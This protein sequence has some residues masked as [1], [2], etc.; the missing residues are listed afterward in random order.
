MCAAGVLALAVGFLYGRLMPAAN[1]AETTSAPVPT[2]DA[3]IAASGDADSTLPDPERPRPRDGKELASEVQ[4]AMDHLLAVFP[5][6]ADALEMNARTE[7]WLGHTAEADRLWKQCLE[8]DSNYVYAY[9]GMAKTAFERG[10]HQEAADLA[11]RAIEIDSS[12]FPARALRAEALIHLRRPQDAIAVLEDHIKLDPRSQGFYLLGQA[13]F[14]LKQWAQARDSLLAAI[15]QYP[16]YAEAYYLLSRTYRE[17]GD[18]EKAAQQLEQYR[19]L[20][21]PERMVQCNRPADVTDFDQMLVTAAVLYSDTGRLLML[22]D[23]TIDAERMWRRAAYFDSK[24]VSVRQSLAFL[25]RQQ[26]RLGE[27]IIWF[28]D[29]AEIEPMQISY[30]LEMGRLFEELDAM[31]AAEKALRHACQI[32]PDQADGYAALADLF[33]RFERNLPEAVTFAYQAVQHNPTAQNLAL[34]SAAYLANGENA[35]ALAAIHQALQL[36]PQSA[37]Y[38][39]VFDAIKNAQ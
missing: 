20:A 11:L 21:T 29:L 12:Q 25:C 14:D 26:G 39:A 33:V 4:A 24:N 13:N 17:L 3:P 23:R 5:N 32:A 31:P 7:Q 6:S 15:Q 34:L 19:K 1:L 9:V 10:E 18:E 22:R 8:L 2:L 27:T 38:R 16:E 35:A 28:K 36:A 30:W 37:S